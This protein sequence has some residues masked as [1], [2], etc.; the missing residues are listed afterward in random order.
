MSSSSKTNPR[1]HTPEGS[2]SNSSSSSSPPSSRS[3]LIC[4]PDTLPST[5]MV[6][7]YGERG[8]GQRAGREPEQHTPHTQLGGVAG[9]TKDHQPW[10]PCATNSHQCLY[11][12]CLRIF[13]GTHQPPD[14]VCGHTPAT[15]YPPHLIKTH[16]TSTST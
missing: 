2:S 9:H 13:N 1:A 11:P 7:W 15:W 8:E 3:S 5:V 14:S 4:L 6:D 12:S 10:L 16:T